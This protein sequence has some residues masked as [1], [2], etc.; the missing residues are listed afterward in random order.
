LGKAG[1]RPITE[2]QAGMMDDVI[3]PLGAS[4]AENDG[5]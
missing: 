2:R 4:K 5:L 1:H 3:E